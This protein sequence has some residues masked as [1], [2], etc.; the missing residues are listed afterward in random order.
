M[1][2]ILSVEEGLESDLKP[3]QAESPS[4]VVYAR[5]LPRVVQVTPRP[6]PVER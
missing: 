6:E 1:Q 5:R 3:H 2:A 4:S